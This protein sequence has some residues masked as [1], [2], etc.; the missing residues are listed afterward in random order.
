LKYIEKI[1]KKQLREIIFNKKGKNKVEQSI[2]REFSKNAKNYN[3]YNIVQKKVAKKLISLLD[4]YPKKII[5]LGCGSGEIYKLIDW[6]LENFIGVDMSKTMCKLH[7]KSDK[8]KILNANY[9]DDL[10]YENQLK[11]NNFDLMISS[12]SLQWCHNIEKVIKN[13]SKISNQCAISIF[14]EG[15]FKT[16]YKKAGLKSF[17]PKYEDI[18]KIVQKYYNIKFEIEKNKLYFSDN[19]SKFRY[20]KKSGVSGG[21]RRLNYIETK[22]LIQ[23]YPLD[24]LE[25]EVLYIK[26]EKIPS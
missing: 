16:I 4:T 9:E 7:P 2:E 13:F 3:E 14:C 1:L 12:S 18:I 19:L 5:D 10:F 17:L 11:N 8:I 26:G 6:E 25:F 23:N 20:I 24:Y 22:Q 21:K 15:T